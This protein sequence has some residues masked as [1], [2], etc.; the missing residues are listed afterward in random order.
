[1]DQDIKDEEKTKIGLNIIN[2][3]MEMAD[4]IEKIKD[5]LPPPDV[6]KTRKIKQKA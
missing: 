6:K 2:T 4:R 3:M 1:M 5:R